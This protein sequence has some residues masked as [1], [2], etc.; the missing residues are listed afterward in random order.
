MAE[1]GPTEVGPWVDTPLARA[2][3]HTTGNKRCALQCTRCD[4][5]PLSAHRAIA[6]QEL[7]W[8]HSHAFQ[9]HSP[10]PTVLGFHHRLV[11]H[12]RL[13]AERGQL[14]RCRQGVVD[15]RQIVAESKEEYATLGRLEPTVEAA[16]LEVLSRVA[17]QAAQGV[18]DFC[19][20][21]GVID[22]DLPGGAAPR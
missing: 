1:S 13:G 19:R 12:A 21:V 9:D 22:P 17:V 18:P 11:Q 2:T 3:F 15:Y 14:P 16:R 4:Q 6:P 5:P 10:Q 7:T 20:V 8:R